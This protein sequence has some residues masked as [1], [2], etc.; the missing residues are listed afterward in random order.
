MAFSEL[1]LKRC[2]RDLDA[3]LAKRRPPPNIRNE[4][5]VGYR[6]D[7]QN[8]EIVEIRPDWRE[9]SIVRGR[10]FARITYVRSGAYWKLYWMR[11][12][13]KWHSYAPQATTRHLSEALDVIDRDEHGCFF[14]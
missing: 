6:I 10:P 14:G 7:K 2:E 8:I 3:F 9:P 1:E 5:D 13:L 4:L 11:A 12:S